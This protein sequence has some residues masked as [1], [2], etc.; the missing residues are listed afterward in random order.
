VW[1]VPRVALAGLHVRALVA[2][3]TDLTGAEPP[4]PCETESCPN[5]IP[6]TRNRHFCGRCILDRRRQRTRAQ[7]AARRIQSGSGSGLTPS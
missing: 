5:T 1:P 2:A 3:W 4:A 6:A 7:R